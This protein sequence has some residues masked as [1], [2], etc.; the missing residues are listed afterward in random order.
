MSATASRIALSAPESVSGVQLPPSSERDLRC[1]PWTG[2]PTEFQHEARLVM[3][4]RLAGNREPAWVYI[5]PT[6]DTKLCLQEYHLRM[7]RLRRI[8]YPA[9]V[10]TYC[11]MTANT[12]DHLLPVTMTGEA[13]R[14]FV[15]TVPA[16]VECNS[17]IS[18]RVGPSIIERRKEAHRHIRKANRRLLEAAKLWTPKELAELGPNLRRRIEASLAKRELVEMRL[19]WPID[20][21]Y[22]LR[23][24][25]RSGFDELTMLELL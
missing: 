24:F 12:K 5:V 17:A 16:C 20:S 13:A 10:C 23:A 3:E 18:D 1:F 6:C 11:G 15:A 14:R 7:M 19:E 2:R 4:D 22:D 21:D 25:Q 9:Y 8:E